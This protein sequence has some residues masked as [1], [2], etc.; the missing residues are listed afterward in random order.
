MP[1][2]IRSLPTII[3]FSLMLCV[4]QA[5]LAQNPAKTQT[6][7]N[8]PAANP[9]QPTSSA[10]KAA[11]SEW[12]EVKVPK[13]SNPADLLAFVAKTKQLKPQTPEQY[14]QMQRGIREA[15]KNAMDL[16]KDHSSKDYVAAEIDFVSSSVLLLGND[17]PEAQ[18]KT[19][20]RF[21]DY[22]TSKKKLTSADLQMIILA[23][24]NLEQLEDLTSARDAYIQFAEILEG[25][26][27]DS[28]TEFISLIKANGR[29]LELIDKPLQLKGSTT[30]D[31]EF[32]IQSL[33]DKY[34]VVCFWASFSPPALKEMNSLK[35]VYESYHEKGFEIVSICMDEDQAQAKTLMDESKW[36]WIQ[37]WDR[38]EKFDRPISLELGISSVPSMI[39]L[40]KEN[41]VTSL[42]INSSILQ[43][44]LKELFAPPAPADSPATKGEGSAEKPAEPGIKG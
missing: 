9:S 19:V 13:T 38:S 28:L 15:C 6:P 11:Q 43:N 29:R 34:V 2:T 35:K 40:D 41:K 44:G 36:P 31:Q 24:Q 12:V 8:A 3:R 27:D 16:I 37:L 42:D 22:L 5:A 23:G 32:D 18:S 7:N 10:P 1:Q 30:N 17:G 21:K 25:K 39:F 4:G 33:K 26:K 14:L 20:A